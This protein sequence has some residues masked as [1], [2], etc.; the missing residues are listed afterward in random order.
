L[1]PTAAIEVD[2]GSVSLPSIKGRRN[3]YNSLSELRHT[4]DTHDAIR[5]I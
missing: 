2:D 1:K 3:S 5:I 4:R